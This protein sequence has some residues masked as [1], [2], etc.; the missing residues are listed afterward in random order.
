MNA[1]LFRFELRLSRVTLLS[2]SLGVAFFQFFL[3]VLYS[4]MRPGETLAGFFNLVPKSLKALFGGEY[5]DILSVNGFLSVLFTHPVNLLLLCTPVI[6]MATR[7]ASGG[8][9]EGR[10]DLIL[11][12]PVSRS[13]VLLSRFASG[14]AASLLLVLSMLAGHLAGT[15]LID[16]PETPD[17]LP[18]ILAALNAY[19]FLLGVQGIA[20]LASAAV[21]LR[22]TAVG[23]IIAAVAF[24]FFL[25]LAAQFW[26]FFEIPAALSLFTYYIP[27]KVVF[28][29]SIPWEDILSLAAFFAV[30]SAFALH[31]FNRKDI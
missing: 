10:T 1:N 14:A 23:I 25:R 3:V 18:F 13:A 5:L 28:L 8:A 19:F 22:S 9:E 20:F 21:Q 2:C 15:A 7:T 24:M 26:D 31:I 17:R 6:A 12:Q 16:L 4:T 30:G 27:S 11:S 29:R